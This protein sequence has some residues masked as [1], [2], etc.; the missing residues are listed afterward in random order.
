MPIIHI[1]VAQ[2]HTDD[3]IREL[4][5]GV[6]RAAVDSL[7]VV[8]SAVRILVHE[9]DPDRWFSGGQTMGDRRAQG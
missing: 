8:E 9:V 3:Q 5:G 4:M 7:S 2:G 1:E 6:H